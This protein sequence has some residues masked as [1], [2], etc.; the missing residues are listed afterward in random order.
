MHLADILIIIFDTIE[1]AGT[2]PAIEAYIAAVQA[3]NSPA[4]HA[5][6]NALN[7]AERAIVGRAYNLGTRTEIVA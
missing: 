5:A 1:Q 3:G 6:W 7:A 2:T 4:Q